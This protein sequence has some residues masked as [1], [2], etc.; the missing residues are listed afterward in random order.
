MSPRHYAA[1]IAALPTKAE[2]QAAL[3]Q[4]PEEWRDLVKTHVRIAWHH[5][6]AHKKQAS[7]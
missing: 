6:S 5:P 4:V 7:R 1:Q 2:R 3:E